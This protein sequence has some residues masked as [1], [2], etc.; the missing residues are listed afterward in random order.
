MS[1]TESLW[2][3]ARDG[4]QHGPIPLSQLKALHAA[5]QIAATDHLWTAQ[6]ENWTLASELFPV[7]S[8]PPPPPAARMPGRATTSQGTQADASFADP[9]TREVAHHAVTQT[10]IEGGSFKFNTVVLIVVGLLI[11]LWPISL[12]ICW[13]FAYQSY[14]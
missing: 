13:Y 6:L 10:T 9:Q 8:V 4:E 12:P 7:R 14:K 11:P 3:I 5:G 2:Y 1:D